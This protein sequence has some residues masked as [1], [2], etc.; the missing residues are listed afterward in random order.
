MERLKEIREEKGF[1]QEQVA[2]VIGI[3][4]QTISQYE[5]GI[6]EPDIQTLKKLCDFFDV[7]SDYL[8]GFKDYY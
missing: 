5:K 6:T 7:T 8:L 1:S 2:K 3:R 4:Q